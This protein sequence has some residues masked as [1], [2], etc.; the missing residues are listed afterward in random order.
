MKKKLQRIGGALVFARD[1]P[2]YLGYARPAALGDVV[3]APRPG[4]RF[5]LAVEIDERPLEALPDGRAEPGLPRPHEPGQ[6]E[7]P[8]ECVQVRGRHRS[9]IRPRYAS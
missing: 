7:V 4:A 9:L 1:P 6:R 8:P 2:L 3:G 5:D